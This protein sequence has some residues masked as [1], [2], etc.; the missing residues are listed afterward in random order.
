MSSLYHH[1]QAKDNCGF[2]MIAHI[3]GEASHQLVET[4]LQA[5]NRMTHR[6][7]VASDGL[8]GDG[9]GLLIQKPEAFL[10]RVAA[11]EGFKLGKDFAVGM[12]FLSQNE[13]LAATC[14]EVLEQEI[15]RETLSVIGWRKVPKDT[16]ICGEVALNSL[17]QIEQIFVQGMPGWSKHDMERRLFIARRRAAWRLLREINCPDYYVSSLS[18][19]VMVYKALVMPRHLAQFYPDLQASDFTS[20]IC[21]FHQRFSTNTLPQWK[22]AQPFRFLA[23]NG[24]INTITGNRNWSKARTSKFVTPLLPDLKE[25]EPLVNQTGSDSSSLDNMLEVF[26][27]GGMDIFRALRLL[28]PPAWQNLPGMD[29][30]L[31]AFYEFN[32]MHIEPWDGPA[33]IVMTNGQHVACTLDRNGLRPARYVITKDNLITLASEVGV[34]DYDEADVLEKGR[35]GPGELLAVDTAMGKIWKSREIDDELKTRHPYREWLEEN[36][37]TLSRYSQETIDPISSEQ[38]LEQQKRFTISEEEKRSI[39]LPLANQGVEA[40]GSMGDD[41]P[42]AV[43]SAQPRNLFDYFRQQFAQVTN[44]PIDSL[45]EKASMSLETCIGVEYNVFQETTGHAYRVVLESPVLT[46]SEYQQLAQLKGKH[47]RHYTV[48]LALQPNETLAEAMERMVEEALSVVRDGVVLLCLSDRELN[49]E[50]V[51]IHAALATGAIH[52]AMIEQGLRC[53][54]NI[55]VCSGYVRDPHHFAV[56]CGLGATAVYPYLAYQSIAALI[57]DQTA[58]ALSEAILNYR[59]GIEY[60]LRK[61]L[62]KMGIS[63]MASYRGAQLFEGL[64]LH[65]EVIRRCFP[66]MA[67]R[68]EGVNFEWLEQHAREQ[69]Q[70]A[71]QQQQP[72]PQGGLLKYQFNGELHA[73]NPDVVQQLQTAV[74][75]GQYDD[76]QQFADTV[77]QRSPLALR[78]LLRL[79][80]SKNPLALEQVESS[81]SIFTRFDSAAMSIGALSPEAHESLAIA[82]NRLGG[83]SNSGEGGE[84]AARFGTL[85]N[86][87]I[88]QIAS[89]RFGVTAHYL[90]NAKVLQIK[91]AQ[92]AKPG[93]GGQLPGHKVTALI[94]QLRHSVPG[95]TLISPPPHHDIYS[96]EDLAQLIFDLKQVNPTARVSVKLVAEPGVGTIAAGVAKAYADMITISGYDGGTGASP[97]SSIKYAGSPWELGLAEVQQAL[98][99]NGLRH[100]VTVQVDGGLKTGLDV[101]KGAILGAE[102]FGFGTGPM[103]ALGCKYLRICHLNNCATGVATQDEQLRQKYFHGLPEKVENYFQFIAQEVRQWLAYLGISKLEDIIGQ[104]HLLKRIESSIDKHKQINLDAILSSASVVNQFPNYCVEQSNPSF[105]KGLL[106]E[107]I[108]AD[109]KLA[110]ESQQAIALSYRIKNYQRSIGAR[111]SGF[112]AETYGAQGVTEHPVQLNFSGTA[113]QSFGVWNSPG[114]QLTV[115]GDANDYVGKGM[116]G[117]RI[118]LRPARVSSLVSRRNSIIGNTC[119]YGATGGELFAAGRAGE[120]FAVRNSG[121]SAVVEGLGAHGCEYMTGGCVVVLGNVGW[122]FAAGMTGGEAFILDQSNLFHEYCNQEF[123]SIER[124]SEVNNP[125][126]VQ[127]LRELIEQHAQYTQSEWAQQILESFEHYLGAFKYVSPKVKVVAKE[128]RPKAKLISLVKAG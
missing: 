58:A 63:T 27:A 87:N 70:R 62:S 89:G 102:S 23:H 16:S 78:D 109:A 68:I 103:V 46:H 122:N 99:E 44:P 65:S 80:P 52:N 111:L 49:A 20:A 6:G 118:V 30:D 54:C 60:G 9:C 64:G 77:N 123:V 24:E 82:M 42:V 74:T 40:T 71:K 98:V 1:S 31:R 72:L 95:V 67:S 106:N 39:L 69:H 29:P 41:T 81:A 90:V 93:E 26:L 32:S 28:I 114:M 38:L 83:N 119:L 120:R 45:R 92:G 94:A 110:V 105:D 125:N 35:V 50:E 115:E 33:G 18:C 107:Q 17:P 75:T 53:D 79:A 97:L 7:A 5:L 127:R 15:R 4:S 117:G 73:Y 88:K 112:I 121:A 13:S 12:V 104:T 51:P 19:M 61:I 84:D 55:I 96:I 11:D 101:I 116:S 34:W 124:L 100:K 2:G 85:K 47:Y 66:G 3:E 59:Q 76:Y 25:I 126:T 86:S 91:V 108:L 113:G 36:H 37:L 57:E 14:R 128:P 21:L 48:R 22:Y 10:R 8:S 56:L 43:L